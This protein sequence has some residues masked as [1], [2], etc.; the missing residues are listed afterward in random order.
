MS[1]SFGRDVMIPI[2]KLHVKVKK[3]VMIRNHYREADSSGRERGSLKCHT[4]QHG[5]V[6]R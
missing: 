4:L 5:S 2:I 3:W 6:R 1:R